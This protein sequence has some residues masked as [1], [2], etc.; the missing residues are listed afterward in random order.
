MSSSF[1]D[2]LHKIPHIN[3]TICKIL[4]VT[5]KTEIKYLKVLGPAEFK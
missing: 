4:I 1:E 5:L 3:V 2:D